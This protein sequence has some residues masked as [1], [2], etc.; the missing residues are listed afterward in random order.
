MSFTRFSKPILTAISFILI[1]WLLPGYKSRPS[2]TQVPAPIKEPAAMLYHNLEVSG[3][4]NRDQTAN[5]ALAE[6]N[7]NIKSFLQAKDIKKNHISE[8]FF[9]E[10]FLNHN[11]RPEELYFYYKSRTKYAFILTGEFD[12]NLLTR[13][14]RHQERNNTDRA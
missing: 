4:Y 10:T 8:S 7:A 1:I 14:L 12:V 3:V 6:I 5:E 9:E 13:Q 11:Q 2:K